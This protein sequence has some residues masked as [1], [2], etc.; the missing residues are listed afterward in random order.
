MIINKNPLALDLLMQD[1][2]GVFGRILMRIHETA[3]LTVQLKA[4]INALDPHEPFFV[5]HTPCDGAACAFVPAPRGILG[6]W[7][8]IRD[9]VIQNYQIIT[10]T[11]WN[12][13]PRDSRDQPGP[14]EGALVGTAVDEGVHRK[15]IA[16]IVRSFDPCLFCSVH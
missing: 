14:L 9:G 8:N 13:S 11:G 12:L 5:Q 16:H 4:W 1:S 15:N 6:H 2:A 10:P 7:V 3:L